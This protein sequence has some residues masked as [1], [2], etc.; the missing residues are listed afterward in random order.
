MHDRLI[1][2]ESLTLE[3]PVLTRDE[4]LTASPQVPTIW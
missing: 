4:S 3:A 2:A 1:A